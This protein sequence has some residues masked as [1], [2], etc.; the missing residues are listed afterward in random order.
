MGD[1]APRQQARPS[2][3]WHFFRR[4]RSFLA[5]GGALGLA[6]E[7][8]R[9]RGSPAA[10]VLAAAILV[11]VSFIGF[12]AQDPKVDGDNIKSLYIL[13]VVPAVALCT[14]WCIDWVRRHSNRLLTGGLLVW[15]A[16]AGF[17]DFRFLILR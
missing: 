4:C 13:D 3:S 1:R 8:I 15:L 10:I 7:A 2:G 11:V 14:G 6:V 12:L 17:Y 5:V 9:R 16:V